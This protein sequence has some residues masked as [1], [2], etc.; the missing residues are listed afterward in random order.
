M[1]DTTTP[2]TSTSADKTSPPV[3]PADQL[4]EVS[5]ADTER[6]RQE[7]SPGKIVTTYPGTKQDISMTVSPADLE[8]H[9]IRS[10]IREELER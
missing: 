5:Q 7:F 6:S 10:S 3:Q 8:A 1:T 2:S 4:T 9:A